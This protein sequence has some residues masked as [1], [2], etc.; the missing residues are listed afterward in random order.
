MLPRNEVQTNEDNYF[1]NEEL[2]HR[3]PVT[4]QAFATI[5]YQDTGELSYMG[6]IQKMSM[7]MVNKMKNCEPGYTQID[8]ALDM[9]ANSLNLILGTYGFPNSQF[10]KWNPLYIPDTFLNSKVNLSPENL[11]VLVKNAAELYG[12]DLTGIADLNTRW[13]YSQDM[14]KPFVITEDG[15]AEETEREFHI[16]KNINRAIVMA[17]VMDSDL[18]NNSPEVSASTA[19]SLGY[20]RMGITA[21]SLAEYIRALGY[22]AI[23]CMNDTALSIP[24]AIDAGLGQL[25]RHGLLITPEYG[26]NVRLCKILTDMPL[27]PDKPIDFGITDFCENCLLC[28][29]SC[30]SGAISTGERTIK[31][32]YNTSNSGV[33]K[34]YI[35]GES[36][37]RF[38]QENGASCANC[39]KACPFTNGFEFIHCIE[40]EKCESWK[41]SCV[42]QS[43][44]ETR[45]KYGYLE[46]PEIRSRAK[47]LRVS[48]RGL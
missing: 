47:I 12:A 17:F 4:R 7:N 36:C 19:A 33:L 40:C 34:W 29:K 39:I 1:I 20:S 27:I 41:G 30:P 9:A 15:R 23:P 45:V 22:Q 25:G 38:W 46:F 14:V 10:L 13:V 24:L 11:T 5:S 2:Y 21:V 28:A 8:N 35:H 37:L 31:S 32:D 42:L 26:S 16:P 43:N 18:Q 48:R 44:T 6:F 3:F